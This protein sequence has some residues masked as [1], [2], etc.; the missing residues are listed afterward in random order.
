MFARRT[1]A[2]PLFSTNESM[3]VGGIRCP[4]AST[5]RSDGVLLQVLRDTLKV[6]YAELCWELTCVLCFCD[7]HALLV[8]RDEVR[9]WEN[10]G[11]RPGEWDKRIPLNG[12]IFRVS[13]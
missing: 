13:P 1:D 11:E 12:G 4:D 8:Q 2:P 9:V 5:L 3:F 10:M 7:F 6:M